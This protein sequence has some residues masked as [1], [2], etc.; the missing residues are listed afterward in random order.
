MN[1]LQLALDVEVTADREEDTAIWYEEAEEYITANVHISE[2][3]DW[4]DGFG[5]PL[6]F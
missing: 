6:P 4:D 5:Y 2:A 1:A 3:E